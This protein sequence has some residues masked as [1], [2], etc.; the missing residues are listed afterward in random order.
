MVET[1]ETLLENAR[2]AKTPIQLVLGGRIDQPVTALVLRRNGPTF[3]MSVGEAV[4]RMDL[5]SIV[6][7]TA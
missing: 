2:Q 6:V 5:A 3:E 7:R 4:L 1:L